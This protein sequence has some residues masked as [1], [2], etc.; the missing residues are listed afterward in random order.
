MSYM[1]QNN[2]ATTLMG[3]SV[4]Q[5]AIGEPLQFFPEMGSK[6][7]D[8][9]IDAYVPGNAPIDNKRAAVSLEFFE[10]TMATGE[11]F[12][13]FMVYPSNGSTATSPATSMVDSG[14]ASTFT[15]PVIS[16]S[17]WTQAG[18]SS[19]DTTARRP[20]SKKAGL[21]TDF[22]HLPGMKILTRDGK[23]VTNSASRGC[24]TKE[25][26]DH[27]H[28]MRIIKA[29]DSCRR[30]K[31]RCD[32][33]HKRSTGSSSKTAKKTKKAAASVA[34]A[35]VS[36]QSAF[37]T[38][39][40]PPSLDLDSL[41]SPSSFDSTISDSM[42]D[43]SMDW[44]QF[45]QFDEEPTDAVPYDFNYEFFF[46]GTGYPTPTSSNSNS[47]SPSLPITPAQVLSVENAVTGTFEGE[48]QV[49]LPPYLN[50]GGEA[51]NTYA[52]FN[53]Y[54]PSSSICL[55]DDP[56]LSKEIAAVP[57]S[58]SSRYRDHHQLF[59][60]GTP[61]SFTS[62]GRNH[63][64]QQTVSMESE[65][66][67]SLFFQE[68]VPSSIG[69][70]RSPYAEEVSHR[71]TQSL[72]NSNSDSGLIAPIP[73]WHV[74]VSPG[75]LRPS[76][77]A[78]IG[79]GESTSRLSVSP[80]AAAVDTSPTRSIVP[81][82]R[83]R[84]SQSEL[85]SRSAGIMNVNSRVASQETQQSLIATLT[86][87][88]GAWGGT[89]ANPTVAE[90]LVTRLA[91]AASRTSVHRLAQHAVSC[92]HD[93]AHDSRLKRLQ[94]SN[95]LSEE[96]TSR[97]VTP[98]SCAV[99]GVSSSPS[100]TSS[101]RHPQFVRTAAEIQPTSTAATSLDTQG[102]IV[103]STSLSAAS[104]SEYS[105][106]VLSSALTTTALFAV[107][108]L[109]RRRGTSQEH[110]SAGRRSFLE[111]PKTASQQDQSSMSDWSQQASIAVGVLLASTIFEQSLPY[112]MGLLIIAVSYTALRQLPT[113][114]VDML[115][116]A[117][118]PLSYTKQFPA[119]L[120][121]G[122]KSTYTNVSE[123][124]SRYGCIVGRLPAQ[125]SSRRAASRLSRFPCIANLA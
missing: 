107:S 63:N 113:P 117:T 38:S 9:M 90:T 73:N 109:S 99:E 4:N 8:E 105:S 40:Q 116:L 41:I 48:S 19:A 50:P 6:Q 42:I 104:E 92:P 78:S 84:Q 100:S 23:D 16:E 74:P 82:S 68:Q 5:P 49:P 35:A 21:T 106:G 51:G 79:D 52:D 98:K 3:F 26:R 59:S 77:L 89:S 80:S 29:C 125:P 65:L 34:A 12:K 75:R 101:S 121:N 69:L 17:Q 58:Q 67:A 46:D 18:T 15:S 108:L 70:D 111:S 76:P 32:P 13:F 114:S 110:F 81:S 103:G 55:D 24:K 57:Y 115:D 47:F 66:Q 54:S 39:E 53:L 2:S 124:V 93:Y 85:L 56:S 119:V 7:L 87:G 112:M 60:G 122:I 37:Q 97:S 33:S 44:T 20:S 91:A 31:I 61:E 120:T 14:Y 102:R 88:M 123:K 86:S 30:K 94:K 118:Q 96:S 64:T 1:S 10:H 72:E 25:Q 43:P 71:P 36:Q 95:I 28:L 83:L 62:Q 11:L 45:V 27:A 22:S